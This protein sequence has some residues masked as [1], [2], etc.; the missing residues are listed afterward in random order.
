MKLSIFGLFW[1][2]QQHSLRQ[3]Q[4]SKYFVRLIFGFLKGDSQS[5]AIKKKN[6]IK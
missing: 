6:E 1:K 3:K 4:G 5:S 2:Q